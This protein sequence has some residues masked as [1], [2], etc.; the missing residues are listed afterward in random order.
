M[1]DCTHVAMPEEWIGGEGGVDSSRLLPLSGCSRRARQPSPRGTDRAGVPFGCPGLS[2]VELMGEEQP[3]AS[4]RV[5][6]RSETTR[7]GFSGS[8]LCSARDLTS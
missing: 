3:L 6:N 2:A 5:F 7:P 8:G 1:H 4:A